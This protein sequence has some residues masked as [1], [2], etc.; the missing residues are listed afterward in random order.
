VSRAGCCAG[1]CA[2][3]GGGGGDARLAGG[4][5]G[6]AGGAS[7]R[8]RPPTP[9]GAASTRWSPPPPPRSA[10]CLHPLKRTRIFVNNYDPYCHINPFPAY[11]T[12]KQYLGSAP[13]SYFCNLT[14]KTKVIGLSDLMTLLIDLG[15]LY[16]KQ[17][18]RA[19]NVFKNTLNCLK[20]N[21]VDQKLFKIQLTRVWEFFTRRW[22]AWH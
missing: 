8:R 4:G 9:A 12:N 5:R 1:G 10:S 14:G 18:Q 15:C 7:Y 3:G 17:T 21:S 16:C 22:N 11:A 20:I 2:G 6:V 19:F 13:K